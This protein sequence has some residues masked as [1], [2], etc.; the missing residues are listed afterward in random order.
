MSKYKRIFEENIGRVESLKALYITMKENKQRDTSS[1][2]LTDL[3]RAAVVFLHSAF[4]EYFRNVLIEWIP[5]RASSDTLKQ[6][7]ISTNAGKKPEKLYLSDLAN[8]RNV[9]CAE[10]IQESVSAELKLKSFNSENDIRSWCNKLGFS[11]EE[12]KAI[13]EID[14]AVHRRHKIVHEA[15]CKEQ[16]GEEK[17]RLSSI[18]P[19]DL[20]AWIAAYKELVALIESHVI[21]WEKENPNIPDSPLTL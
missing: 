3:L 6:I 14:A 15:D 17:E 9:T 10:I 19:A 12:C 16:N 13:K 5:I 20:T 1:Y 21:A 8:F 4:E 2:R 18:K 11:L 7:P